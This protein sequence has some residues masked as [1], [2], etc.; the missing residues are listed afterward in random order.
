MALAALQRWSQGTK[1]FVFKDVNMTD[2]H[3]LFSEI[4]F[5]TDR[6]TSIAL[7]VDCFAFFPA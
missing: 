6:L 2:A 5:A 3:C 4:L 1:T 7:P